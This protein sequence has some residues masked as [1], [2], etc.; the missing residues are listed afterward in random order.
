VEFDD[1][2]NSPNPNNP[3]AGEASVTSIVAGTSC[4]T[5]GIMMGTIKVTL[6]AAT[7][8]ERGTCADIAVGRKVGVKGI[9][10]AEHQVL[11]QQIV[12]KGPGS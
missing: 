3:V 7:V 5:L 10:T 12:F 6:T 8:F 9:V 4:P 2:N 11:G 1:D